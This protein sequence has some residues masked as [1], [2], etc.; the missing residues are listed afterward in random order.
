M[1]RKFE[2]GL[3]HKTV[4]LLAVPLLFQVVFLFVTDWF[5][6]SEEQKAEYSEK[7][8][9]ITQQATLVA[10]KLYDALNT[11]NEYQRT[12]DTN[13]QERYSRETER[14]EQQVSSLL[15]L[16]A[17]RAREREICDRLARHARKEIKV[18]N[19]LKTQ[20]DKDDQI[21]AFQIVSYILAPNNP[22]SRISVE[23]QSLTD[24]EDKLAEPIDVAANK[25]R[26]LRHLVTVTGIL[27]NSIVVALM[28]VYFHRGTLS[29]LAILMENTKKLAARTPLH[30]PDRN[31]DEIGR[32]DRFFHEMAQTL[33]EVD[34][35][36]HEFYGMISHDLRTPLTSLSGTLNLV[37]LD[38]Y[39]QLNETGKTRI[40]AAENS[41]R[42][43][44]KLIN[45]ILDLEKITAGK[46]EL[47]LEELYLDD[48][49]QDSV[50]SVRSIAEAAD[51]TLEAAP[52]NY[53]ISADGDRMT[54]VFVNLLSNA[55]KFSPAKSRINIEI[56][57]DKTMVEISVIDRGRG[58]PEHM[59][60][61]IFDRFR[62]VQATDGKQGKGTGLGLAISKAIVEEHKGSISVENNPDAGCRFR[63]KIPR[64]SVD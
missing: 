10:A 43:L 62:Q 33:R 61:A 26:S 9:L 44:I 57:A 11:L 38:T 2:P 37:R 15:L 51:I 24:L 20:I 8:R 53:Y 58:I 27:A 49:L 45:E 32:L 63:I 52:C 47:V 28:A 60:E 4:I 50:E 3:G 39:G 22:L 35:M 64:A 48:I 36:K 25:R 17:D 13:S 18:L 46:M 42:R 16:V 23:I 31:A 6:T 54:Q 59:K 40:G 34:Q 14:V 1:V 41:V 7:S 21:T 5:T 55:I 30:P 12:R 19:L 29:R 56:S